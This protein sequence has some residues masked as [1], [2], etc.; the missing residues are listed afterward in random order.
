MQ[1]KKDLKQYK[2]QKIAE[3]YGCDEEELME[4]YALDSIVPGICMNE[5]CDFVVDSCEP[6]ARENWC[7]CCDDNSVCSVVEL[8]LFS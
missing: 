7:E 5:D 1:N 8:L 3:E 4:T 6:D 2:I